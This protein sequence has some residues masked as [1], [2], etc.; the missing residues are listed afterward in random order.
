M[1][2]QGV[3]KNFAKKS[4]GKF[5][6]SPGGQQIREAFE[7]IVDELGN[8]YT[9]GYQ[10]TNTKADGK[11]REIEVKITRPNLNIRTRDGYYSEKK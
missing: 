11:W 1:L 6:E 8:Q 10:P 4:G 7:N 3:L 2:N 5:V 9:F